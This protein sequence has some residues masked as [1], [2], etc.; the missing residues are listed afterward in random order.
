[1]F[2]FMHRRGDR[3]HH[4]HDALHHG[5]RHHGCR[6]DRHAARGGHRG[7]HGFGFGFGFDPR[8][9][10][11]GGPGR[12]PDGFGA[13]RKLSSAD[14]QLLILALLAE[15]AR[16]GYELI[17]ELDERSKGYYV[18]SPGM[19]YPALSYLEEIGYASV[20]AEGS[21]KLYTVTVAGLNQLEQNRAAADAMLEQLAWAGL[22]MEQ[23][24][25]AMGQGEATDELGSEEGIRP[26]DWRHPMSPAR[27]E[28]RDAFHSLKD[29]MRLA[30]ARAGRGN[31]DEQR[32]LLDILRRATQEVRGK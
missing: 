15:R 25:Q 4:R 2:D 26:G 27:Q 10:G 22:R 21:K 7:G 24:R 13:G 11:R 6:G 16:H 28:L 9:G 3:H 12:G 23:M 19:I 18:P 31:E 30:V 17:K 29:E 1:M 8:H 32:R 5:Q 14:L 20:E